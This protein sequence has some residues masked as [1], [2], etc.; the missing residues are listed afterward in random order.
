MRI[1][2]SILFVLLI[3]AQTHGTTLLS[4]SFNDGSLGVRGW[5]DEYYDV[6]IDTST[7]YSGAGS[8]R[9]TFEEGAD[10]CRNEAGDSELIS[11]RHSFTPSDQVY[12]SFYWMFNTD[13]VGSGASYHPHMFFLLDTLWGNLAGGPLR[14]YIE[15]RGATNGRLLT[16]IIGRGETT[17]WHETS[18]T[19]DFSTWYHVETWAVMNT[20]GQANG[21]L[22]VW[23][24]GASVL[25][26]SN[27]TFR[28]DADIHF[29]AT[30]MAPYIELGLG[31]SPQ[32]QTMWM[33]ELTIT[34]E[35]PYTSTPA[36]VQ[37]VTVLG[38]SLK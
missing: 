6:W 12:V 15:P 22:K 13:W 21:I 33:D 31:G 1:I 35:E 17:D 32:D 28:T 24:G 2:L 18:C 10:N 20:V 11:V 3:A 25:D 37:G 19:F 7:H 23:V 36:K 30:A 8:W 16:E 38:G 9:V 14:L 34:D 27:V 26:V 5:E 29:G 4:E